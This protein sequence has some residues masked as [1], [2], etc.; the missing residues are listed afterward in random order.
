MPVV[1]IR[2]LSGSRQGDRFEIDQRELR[3]GTAADGDVVFDTPSDPGAAG[4]EVVFRLADD[5]WT[6]KS[7]GSGQVMLNHEPVEGTVRIRSGD[8]VRLSEQGPD[9]SF[10]I[11]PGPT[12]MPSAPAVATATPELAAAAAGTAPPSRATD[13][14]PAAQPAAQ[15]ASQPAGA[16]PGALG[17]PILALAVLAACVLGILVVWRPWSGDGGDGENKAVARSSEEDTRD[18]SPTD[19]KTDRATKSTGNSGVGA[20]DDTNAKATTSSNTTKIGADPPKPEAKRGEDPGAGLEP[21]RPAKPDD[22]WAEVLDALRPT[23]WLLV[24]EDPGGKGVWPFA[25]ATAVGERTLLTSGLAVAELARFEAEGWKVSAVSRTLGKQTAVEE[26]AVHRG[27]N[28]MASEP[29]R[30]VYFEFGRVTVAQPLPERALIATAAELAAI[31]RGMPV[32]SV[33]IAH[34]GEVLNRFQRLVPELKPASIFHV[35]SLDADP[36]SPRLL[37]VKAAL[38]ENILGSPIVNREGRVIGVYVTK[39]VPPPDQN[40]QDLNIHYVVGARLVKAA[41]L[42]EDAGDW[43]EPAAPEPSSQPTP[44]EKLPAPPSD[45]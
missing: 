3:V 25:T 10:T 14:A 42:S 26:L 31:E 28:A 17:G 24:V 22:P 36:A 40:V 8:I 2:V 43:V 41:M 1:E 38:P 5:G 45:R 9:F 4:R 23:V 35:T 7:T 15:P 30:R 32:A 12:G 27:F 11:L 39:A 34:D 6:V 33:A 37:H 44:P 18:G 13:Q 16:G 19:A 21:P 29:A 20:K